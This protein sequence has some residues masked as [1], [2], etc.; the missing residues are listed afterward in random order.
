MDIDLG[1]PHLLRE[2]WRVKPRLHVFGH[3]HYAYGKEPI[4]FDDL[5][6]AYERL[7]ALPRRGFFWDFVPNRSWVDMST[8]VLQGIH[9]VMWKWIM[10]GPGSNHGSLMVNAAQMHQNSGKVISRA[11][12][13][14]I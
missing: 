10:G 5:Q 13:V 11:I 14:D 1:C 8:I 7:M 2:V 9:A 6:I 4:Y 12:V 3:C